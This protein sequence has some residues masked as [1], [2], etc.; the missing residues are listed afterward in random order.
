MAFALPEAIAK[1]NDNLRS[2]RRFVGFVGAFSH[3]PSA[4]AVS[5][6]NLRSPRRFV[7]FVGAFWHSPSA[8]AVSN[9]NLRSP[10]RFVGFVGAFW[11]SPSAGAVS[12][13][14]LRSPRRVRGNLPGRA[15]AIRP[16][17]L[18]TL[19]KKGVQANAI[20]PEGSV[21]ICLGGRMAFAPTNCQRLQKRANAIRP[22]QLPTVSSGRT[23]KCYS[24]RRVR[25]IGPGGRMPYALLRARCAFHVATAKRPYI[26]PTVY[27]SPQKKFNLELKTFQNL[28][29]ILTNISLSKQNPGGP[30]G[31]RICS[32]NIYI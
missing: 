15:N 10:I 21:V 8:G 5:N 27:P 30:V 2:P 32:I 6:G 14:N 18:P 9:G 29:N 11:H 20:R 22:Y 17:I 1:T 24:P 7:G 23:G 16:Y 13:G 26:L 3:S 28:G 31:R 19:A 12:N 25:G 4:G